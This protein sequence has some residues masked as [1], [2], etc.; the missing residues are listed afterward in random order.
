VVCGYFNISIEQLALKTRKHQIVEARQIAM[1]L[2]KKYSSASLNAIGQQCG[3]KDHAT[4][5]HA[6][7]TV[8]DRLETD[9]QFK[10]ML[11]EIEKKITL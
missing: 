1:Y 4:V 3:K 9:R 10:T 6:C 2:S 5:Y 11:A 7:K 8:S